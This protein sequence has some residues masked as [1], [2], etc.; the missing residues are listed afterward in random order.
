MSMVDSLCIDL[1][2]E[3]QMPSFD[4]IYSSEEWYYKM[5]PS[6][7]LEAYLIGQP[8]S[9]GNK[10]LDLGC[11]EGRDSILLARHGFNVTAVDASA[12]AIRKLA[13]FTNLS[14][15]PIE[16]HCA[17]IEAYEITPATYDAICAVTVLDHLDVAAGR[18]LA[19]R[20]ATGV[21]PGGFVFVEVFTTEDPGYTR[22]GDASETAN[23]VR[24]YFDSGELRELFTGWSIV[25]YE[26]KIEDDETHGPKHKHGVAILLAIKSLE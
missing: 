20:I 16:A 18:D 3:K 5:P 10:A 19:R 26:E 14:K 15:L 21:R 6:E 24:H 1:R 4:E 22:L 13:A 9:G 12:E 25:L 2:P 23:F 8:S 7:E 11:G 17:D